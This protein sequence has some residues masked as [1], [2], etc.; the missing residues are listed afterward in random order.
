MSL[1]RVWCHLLW[2]PW[3]IGM[4]VGLVVAVPE[5][6][7]LLLPYLFWLLWMSWLLL[8]LWLVWLHCAWCYFLWLWNVENER[9]SQ[10]LQF[11]LPQEFLSFLCTQSPKSVQIVHP[12]ALA[13]SALPLIY[14]WALLPLLQQL[15]FSGLLCLHPVCLLFPTTR[16]V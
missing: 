13:L 16:F 5:D 12:L 14:Y 4:S 3:L 8:L 15:L 9:E 11:L 2:L 10:F 1:L 6:G 7:R